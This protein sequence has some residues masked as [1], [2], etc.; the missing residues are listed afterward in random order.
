MTTFVLV[1]GAWHGGWWW[2]FIA[3]ALRRAGHDVYTPSL[4]GLGDRAHL[5]R[6]G[7]DL[8]RHVQNAIA[9]LEMEDLHEIVL[10]GHSYGGMVVDPRRGPL[11]GAHSPPG[12][13]RRFRSRE[14]EVRARLRSAWTRRRV[15]QRWRAE[16]LDRSAAALA[17]GTHPARAHRTRQAAR[18]ETSLQQLY[19]TDPARG[20]SD[21]RAPAQDLHLSLIARERYLRLF[22]NEIP[23]PI[24]RGSSSSSRPATTP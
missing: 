6:P 18:D 8:E 1:H 9:L 19:P 20:R 12:V 16:R 15:P 17:V 7:I 24:G 3:P 14:R 13:A 23:K 5:A 21:A 11:R 22:R 10:V 2:R 4:T